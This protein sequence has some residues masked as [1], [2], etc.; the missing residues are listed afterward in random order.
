MKEDAIKWGA[1]Q[2][3]NVRLETAELGGKNG[4]GIVSVEI[5]AYGTGVQ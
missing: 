1:R 5:I 2:V 3:V 4:N